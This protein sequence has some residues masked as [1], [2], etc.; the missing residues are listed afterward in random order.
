MIVEANDDAAVEWTKPD[1]FAVDVKNPLKG[2]IGHYEQ[3]F[4]AAFGDGSVR[5]IQRTI[6]PMN[7]LAAF[8][9]DGGEVPDFK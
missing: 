4:A 6:K 8:T 5:L 2:L 1:D 7:L 9:R 3:G